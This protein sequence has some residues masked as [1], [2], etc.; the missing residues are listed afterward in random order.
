MM[1]YNMVA[2]MGDRFIIFTPKVLNMHCLISISCI[3]FQMVE[4][5]FHFEWIYTFIFLSCR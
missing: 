5:I 4:I 3:L 2:M 1:L